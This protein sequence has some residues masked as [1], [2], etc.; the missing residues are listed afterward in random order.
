MEEKQLE[1]MMGKKE[2]K[3]FRRAYQSLSP[4]SEHYQTSN[5]GNHTK[6]KPKDRGRFM[7]PTRVSF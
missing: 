7:S 1:N 5:I 3:Q 6:G 2:Y 4:V